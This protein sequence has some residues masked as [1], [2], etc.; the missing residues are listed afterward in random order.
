MQGEEHSCV[1]IL[2]VGKFR[3][4][5]WDETVRLGINLM[6]FGQREPP[7][8]PIGVAEEGR[9]DSVHFFLVGPRSAAMAITGGLLHAAVGTRRQ[10][11]FAHHLVLL[12]PYSIWVAW[13]ARVSCLANHTFSPAGHPP[14]P[15][16]RTPFPQTNPLP[17]NV[18]LSQPGLPVLVDKPSRCLQTT[19]RP[20]SS[21]D[22]AGAAYWHG[23]LFTVSGD[24]KA[25]VVVANLMC[26][27][28]VMNGT[29]SDFN[30]SICMR[31]C[32][33]DERVKQAKKL[34]CENECSW[35]GW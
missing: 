14:S 18:G 4:C 34:K 9:C 22:L 12:N 7:R 26:E 29:R 24:G 15:Q 21:A 27:K 11:A 25:L 1:F 30:H 32:F 23:T 2:G 5:L 10:A 13:I 33:D 6:A 35:S 19:S 16:P 3:R 8:Q 31:P 20:L 17:K 28:G